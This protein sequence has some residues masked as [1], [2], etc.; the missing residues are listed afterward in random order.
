MRGSL[1]I[2]I[3]GVD[4]G[5]PLVLS[6]FCLLVSAVGTLFRGRVPRRMSLIN[7]AWRWIFD[8]FA[9]VVFV[10]LAG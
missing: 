7:L 10:T 9:L 2:R 8:F 5:K 3:W 1:G 6:I 4:V